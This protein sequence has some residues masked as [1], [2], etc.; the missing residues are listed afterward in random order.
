MREL[1][2]RESLVVCF[3]VPHVSLLDGD[4]EVAELQVTL[5]PVLIDPFANDVV[6]GPPHLPEDFFNVPAMVFGYGFFAGNSADYLAAIASG[7]AP[8]DFVGFDDM[9]VVTAF[10]K[11]QGG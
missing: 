9:D 2:F 11:M 5:N 3:D 10:R 6:S 8:A 7:G 1:S 4:I